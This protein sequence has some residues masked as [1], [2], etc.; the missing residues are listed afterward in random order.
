MELPR[1]VPPGAR[2]QRFDGNYSFFFSGDDPTAP[3]PP[4]E[5]DMNRWCELNLWAP[6]PEDGSVPAHAGLMA[7]AL[8][9]SA[10]FQN[11]FRVVS[12]P[13]VN[14]ITQGDPHTDVRIRL[15]TR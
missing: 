6:I 9:S 8:Q 5:A 7:Q 15:L 3:P 11:P 1:L 12:G 10:V 4:E 13:Q 2:M 14:L